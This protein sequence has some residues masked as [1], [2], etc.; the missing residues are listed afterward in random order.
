MSEIKYYKGAPT[1]RGVYAVRVPTDFGL[2]EDKFLLWYKDK[3]SYLG[4]P[5]DYRGKVEYFFGPFQRK[6]L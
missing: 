1:E 5:Q 6:M 3:W 4:S 2:W